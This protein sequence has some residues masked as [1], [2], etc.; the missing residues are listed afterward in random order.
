VLLFCST[1][2][3]KAVGDLTANFDVLLGFKD[4]AQA[5]TDQLLVVCQQNPDH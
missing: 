4:G 3:E 1:H 2:G 5:G